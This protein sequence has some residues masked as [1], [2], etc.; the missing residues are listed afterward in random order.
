MTTESRTPSPRASRTS[1]VVKIRTLPSSSSLRASLT[2]DSSA[3]KRSRRWTSV[4]GRFAVSWRPSVQSSAE[5]PPPTITQLL[6]SNTFFSRT[7]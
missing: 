1:A 7:K 6:P 3:R 2:E 4:I 5:S